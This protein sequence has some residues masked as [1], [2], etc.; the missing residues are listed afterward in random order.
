MLANRPRADAW[1]PALTAAG[2]LRP[3]ADQ[4]LGK[5]RS[6][7]DKQPVSERHSDADN[8]GGMAT[9]ANVR[10]TCK[11]PASRAAGAD[12]MGHEPGRGSCSPPARPSSD[13]SAH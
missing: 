2:Q 1:L 8:L 4:E 13:S 9:G 3:S 11:V 6:W 10:R 7:A 5:G 12:F